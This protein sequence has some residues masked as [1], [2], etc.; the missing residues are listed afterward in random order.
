MNYNFTSQFPF[1]WT[2][3]N[4][5]IP[6]GFA[7]ASNNLALQQPLNST[8]AAAAAVA[9]QTPF[10]IPQPQ[11]AGQQSQSYNCSG[12]IGPGGVQFPTG[13]YPY[14]INGSFPSTTNSFPPNWNFNYNA[15][16]PNPDPQTHVQSSGPLP[17]GQNVQQ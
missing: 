16:Q 10:S 17:S 12:I 9:S 15:V 4:P 5:Y 3:G 11:Q 14:G 2:S 1:P 8:A 6:N 13:V 7:G